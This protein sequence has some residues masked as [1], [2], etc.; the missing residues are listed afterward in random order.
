MGPIPYAVGPGGRQNGGYEVMAPGDYCQCA[1][2]GVTL[3]IVARYCSSTV[4]GIRR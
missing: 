4:S 3:L 1:H 2:S